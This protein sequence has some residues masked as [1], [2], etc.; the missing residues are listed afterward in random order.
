MT[1]GRAIFGR[2]VEGVITLSPV[3]LV[4][5]SPIGL[6]GM[7]TKVSGFGRRAAAGVS[8]TRT[9]GGRIGL[10]IGTTGC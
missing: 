4:G 8:P 10:I 7:L 1:G 2:T 9:E 5:T 3:S 6:A